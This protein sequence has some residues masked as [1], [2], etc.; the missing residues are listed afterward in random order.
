MNSS[1][2]QILII[3]DDPGLSELLN[4][5]LSEAGYQTVCMHTA[6]EAL[7]W[8]IGNKP[9]LML[10]D[11]RLPDMNGSEFIAQLQESEQQRP[12]FVVSTGQGDERI[13]VEMM[14]LGA[15]DYI[16][17]DNQF[18]DLIPLVVRKVSVTIDNEC[19][20]REAE[21]LLKANEEKQRAMIANIYD[22]IAIID[23]NGVN[24]YKSPNIERI[25]GWKPEEVIGINSIDFVHADD[26]KPAIMFLTELLANP[27]QA[28]T[29]ELRYRCKNGNYQWIELFA[30]N[31]LKN[32]AIGGL[33]L[34]YHDITERKI[35]EQELIKAKEKAEESDRLKTAFL[36][37]MSHEIRTPMNAIIGFASLLPSELDDKETLGRFCD[38]INT[39]CSD[40][41]SI[42]DNILDI[43]K[44]ESAQLPLNIQDIHL[45]SFFE[46][47]NNHFKEQQKIL[48]NEELSF[49]FDAHYR[50]EIVDVA[51]D[52]DKVKQ[53]VSNVLHNAFKFTDK[54]SIAW[55]CTVDKDLLRFKISDTGIGIP[56][57]KHDVIFERFMQ[58]Y[59]GKNRVVSGTGLGLSIARGLVTMLG[60]A[61][62]LESEPDKGTTFYIDIPYSPA[63]KKLLN[64]NSNNETSTQSLSNQLVLIVED[65]RYNAEYLKEIL[66]RAGMQVVHSETGQEALSE[67]EM[68][69]FA[70]ILMD[71]RLPDTNGY[72]LCSK[73]LQIKPSQIIVAQTAYSSLGER[74]KALSLGCKEYIS[75]PIKKDTLLGM[76]TRL[77]ELGDNAQ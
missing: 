62:W 49:L 12:P 30:S 69:D 24:T 26:V 1:S 42:I 70:I 50:A 29:I 19:K 44:I 39:R 20:L 53:I 59:P 15:R 3:E 38:I 31:Q 68:N 6:C 63:Q 43:A 16:I 57:N 9:Y 45:P 2:K 67:Y 21:L 48:G 28:R 14:K 7:A 36:Q 35:A 54:G 61:I 76:L 5:L 10:L 17:K 52:K 58:L 40:L 56:A 77:L 8:L 37:N 71:I 47:I 75:K 34:N 46:S 32:N 65:D 25:F 51:I 33:L 41:L 72:E 60:G 64:S 27:Q 18:L 22:V 11:Y 13:A 23:A 55:Q 66:H 4:D 74:E 73:L